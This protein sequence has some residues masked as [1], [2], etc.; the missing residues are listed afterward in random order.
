[1]VADIPLL[2][3]VG[4]EHEFD[5]VVLVDAPES[6]REERLVQD[7]GL[8]AQDARRMIEAQM[9]SAAKR[10]RA[11][12]IIDN[13]GTPAE[14]QRRAVDVWGELQRRVFA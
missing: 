14:L 8:S 9:P 2:F 4:L 6:I 10:D 7:R 11:D 1:V 12:Y 3:E 5:A 13:T